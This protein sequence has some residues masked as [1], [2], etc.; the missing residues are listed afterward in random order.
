M[1][2]LSMLMLM[3]MGLVAPAEA[4]TMRKVPLAHQGWL[5][6]ARLIRQRW[7][8]GKQGLGRGHRAGAAAGPIVR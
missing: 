5:G 7:Q 4:Q 6:S 2:R 8:D 1:R 3:L